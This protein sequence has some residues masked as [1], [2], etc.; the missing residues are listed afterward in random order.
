MPNRAEVN[1]KSLNSLKR[2]REEEKLENEKIYEET[3]RLARDHNLRFNMLP[4]VAEEQNNRCA[5]A[6]VTCK[7]VKDGKPT[8][9]C[10][11]GDREVE[12][13][14]M[15]LDHITPWYKTRDNSR[16]NLQMLCAYCH[17]IKSAAE[18]R[19]RVSRD[20]YLPNKPAPFNGEVF[21]LPDLN[22]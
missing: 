13:D 20:D 12:W 15:Q 9:V 7:I 14:A 11:C 18:A 4:I 21:Q 3:R 2:K 17:A 6:M 16:E 19:E 10:P 1:A 8:P 22:A 5:N